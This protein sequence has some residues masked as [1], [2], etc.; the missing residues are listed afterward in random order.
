M[1]VALREAMGRLI[2]AQ[3]EHIRQSYWAG[4]P[5]PEEE[6]LALQRV[7]EWVEDFFDTPLEEM[8]ATM[9]QMDERL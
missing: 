5:R 3:A 7:S 4:N 1:T 6:R 8:K 9:E 2:E